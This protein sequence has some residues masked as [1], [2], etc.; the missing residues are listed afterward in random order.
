M[1]RIAE[2]TDAP[3]MAA[4]HAACFPPK[5]AWSR[6]VFQ[7]Q[8]A[9]PGVSGLLHSDGG[10]IVARIAADEAEILTLAILPET[11]RRGVARLLLQ[12]TVRQMQSLGAVQLFL[13]VS[14]SNEPARALYVKSGFS[15]VGRRRNYYSDHSDALVLCQQIAAPQ[16][17]DSDLI[18]R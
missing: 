11:R 1:V 9:L 17:G 2:I 4:I 14:V 18:S 16:A 13:E 15:E 10:L 6:D 12:E 7:L 3:V 5:E 8:L